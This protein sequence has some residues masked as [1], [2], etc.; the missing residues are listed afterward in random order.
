[1]KRQSALPWITFISILYLTGISSLCAQEQVTDT[2]TIYHKYYS[3]TFSKSKRFPVVVKYWLTKTMLDCEQKYK[4]SK[5]FQPDPSIPAYTN[6]DKDYK[7]SGY[8]RGHQMDG[9]DCGCDSIAMAE[10]FYYSNVAPQ[11]PALNRGSWKKL[12]DYTRK[13]VNEYD[14]ILVWCG[15]IAIEGNHIGRVTIPDYCWKIIFIKNSGIVKAYS[16][17]NDIVFIGGLHFF[18]VSVDS[19]RNLTGFN[20]ITN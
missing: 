19:I 11:L 12:E 6:L 9:Y 3:T 8:D 5:K 14:S 2:I 16:F 1:M 18:E 7:K 13:L 15:S 10:S 17:R 20:L 4:R